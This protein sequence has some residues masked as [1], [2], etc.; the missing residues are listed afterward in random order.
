MWERVKLQR[1]THLHQTTFENILTKGEIAH[2]E[3]FPLLPQ[4]FQLYLIYKLLFMEIFQIMANCFS[5]LSAAKLAY[6]GNS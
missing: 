4:C 5:K 1:E 6:V 2:E 3:Q